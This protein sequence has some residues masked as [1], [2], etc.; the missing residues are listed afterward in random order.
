MKVVVL[1]IDGL[2]R[3]LLGKFGNQL[4]NFEKIIKNSSNSKIR[5]VFPPDSPTAWATIYTGQNP[6][7]HGFVFFKDP[8]THIEYGNYLKKNISGKTFWDEAGKMGKKVCVLFPHMGYP[9]WRV[10]GI[11]IGRTTEV[12]IKKFDIE[13]FPGNIKDKYDLSA[14]KPLTSFPLDIGQIIQPTK[15]LIMNEMDLAIQL[16]DDIDWD[17]YFYYSSSLDNIQHL[18]WMY[19]DKNDPFYEKDNP[20]ENVIPD[21][22]KFYDENV[23]GPFLNKV[24]EETTL[25]VVS[26]HGHS[27]RPVNIVNINEILRRRGLLKLKNKKKKTNRI[28]K[29]K[30]VTLSLIDNH[31]SIGKAASLFLKF[32]PK[33]LNLFV[34]NTPIDGY[35]S[36]AYLAD[37]SGGI[38]A[39]SYAGIRINDMKS[40][41][42]DL[43][44]DIIKLLLSLRGPDGEKIVEWAKK[45]ENLY[46]GAQIDKYPDVV[47]KLVDEW[48]V[49]WEVNDDIF[50]KSSSHKLHSGNH[51]AETPVFMIYNKNLNLNQQIDLMDI[52]NIILDLLREDSNL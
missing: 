12:D 39:Y 35:K 24:D 49:G 7:Q 25:I 45:R 34:K 19:Y 33:G 50:S 31:R 2:D 17:L 1:G 6:A 15:E 38:K 22:Y 37:P 29:L 21:F 40:D 9:V 52:R 26:D 44:D 4:P 14:L 47:F 41:Y 46:S 48:G 30:R 27:M 51:K 36:T 43:R 20:Y 42:E 8:F 32:F 18:F 23:L 3:D 5:S 28:V 13:C 16:Y 10:N 11:M